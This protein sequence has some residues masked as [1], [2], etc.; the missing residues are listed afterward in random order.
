MAKDEKSSPRL[1]KLASKVL[2]GRKKPTKK[3]ILSLAGAV[4]TESPDK[5]K[6]KAT[7]R[8]AGK[9]AVKKRGR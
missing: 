8:K 7:G 3:E 4:L 2:S 6:K 5:P 1:R 9:K